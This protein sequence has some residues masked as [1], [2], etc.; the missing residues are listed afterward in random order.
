[1]QL[2]AY[3]KKE[4]KFTRE[5]IWP[6]SIIERQFSNTAKYTYNSKNNN[7]YIGEPVTKDVCS[8]CNNQKLS[9]IDNCLIQAYEKY[10]CN[11]IHSGDGV[12]FE[13]NYENL[14]RGLLKISFNSAR[15]QE[16]KSIASA[17]EQF[18]NYILNGGYKRNVM[19]RLQ[20]VTDT[21]EIDIVTREEKIFSPKSLRVDTIPYDGF[22]RNRFLVRIVAINSFYFY[23]IISF[24]KEAPHKWKQ[25]VSAFPKWRIQSG[26]LVSSRYNSI[27]IGVEK[28]TFMHDYL[29][30]KLLNAEVSPS[31][32]SH[33]SS[34][35]KTDI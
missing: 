30:R 27:R 34:N 7:F 23:I 8:E 32:I 6:K 26:L 28:T 10:F 18:A 11:I 31:L 12:F 20:I 14:L 4:N 1:M 25:F 3:C 22:L 17:H 29:L 35:S 2:Y 19:L 33:I 15:S 9:N 24:K 5:H 13:Y 21:K 16:N